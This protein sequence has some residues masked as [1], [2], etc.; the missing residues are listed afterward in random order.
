MTIATVDYVGE[1]S[2]DQN[3]QP[4]DNP[5]SAPPTIDWDT[6]LSE[7]E[8]DEDADG[9]PITNTAGDYVEGIKVAIPDFILTVNR[10]FANWD[11][12]A[13]AAY[14]FSTN[15]DTFAGWAP[16][17]GKI[18]K[19]K[20]TSVIGDPATRFGYWKATLQVRFRFPF[21]TTADKAWYARYLN[22]GFN[23]LVPFEENNQT[24]YE[25]IRC[26]DDN[27]QPVNRPVRLDFEGKRITIDSQVSHWNERRLYDPLPYSLLGFLDG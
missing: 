16:G 3:G 10:N 2:I 24:K 22:Q 6:S 8:I 23:E 19:L 26:V 25:K 21:R 1:V 5:L 4:T 9:E 15:S 14:S 17:T 13:Q 27:R 11:T 18:E 7:E 20:A 12:Y